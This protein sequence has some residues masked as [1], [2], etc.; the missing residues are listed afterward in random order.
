MSYPVTPNP[1]IHQLP[2]AIAQQQQQQNVQEIEASASRLLQTIVNALLSLLTGGLLGTGSS[3]S[4]DAIGFFSNLFQNFFN[5][6]G[7]GNPADLLATVETDVFNS[8][9]S[10]ENFVTG[11]LAPTG[12]LSLGS[13]VENF[14]SG[15]WSALTGTAGTGK[16]A[17]DVAT[18][19]AVLTSKVTD[20]ADTLAVRDNQSTFLGNG[21]TEEVT[22]PL[23]NVTGGSPLYLSLTPTNAIT[24]FVRIGQTV[25]KD[26]ITWLGQHTT[27]LTGFYVSIYK[28]DT[29]TGDQTL[30]YESTNQLTSV[31]TLLSWNTYV[32]P[33]G[34][35]I[36]S[37]P[38]DVYGIELSVTGSGTYQLIGTNQSWLPDHP[39][40]FPKQFGAS[41][42]NANS[43]VAPATI[44]SGAVTY[45]PNIPFL[46]FGVDSGNG[47]HAPAT[48]SFASAGSGSYAIPSWAKYIDMILMGGGGSSNSG[49]FPFSSINGQGGAGGAWNAVTAQIGVDIPMTTTTIDYV[50]GAGGAA[51]F[52]GPGANGANTTA[53]ATGWTGGLTAAGG[54]AGTI[55][56][57]NLD[58]SSSG[59]GNETFSGTTYYGGGIQSTFSAP[60]ISPGGGA[61]GGSSNYPGASG[62]NGVAWFVARAS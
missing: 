34:S 43:G 58:P 52:S 41:R 33:A 44:A 7:I 19:M 30:V 39:T 15:I 13:D 51:A 5:M 61:G 37:V 25:N 45:S 54:A 31:S 1:S 53:S 2:A 29:T 48:T 11:V 22:F 17:S 3:S 47:F 60:G 8:V 56:G 38:G 28:M 21:P 20:H 27:G 42:N 12:L 59:A 55:N 49:G 57:L 6:L 23:A 14:L 32:I 46:G 4:I 62:A 26:A 50:V 10:I 35:E 9:T 18:A 40:N 36:G 24:G 16:S